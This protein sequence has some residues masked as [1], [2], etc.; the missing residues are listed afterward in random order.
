LRIISR[1]R[2]R[3]YWERH[4]DALEPLPAWYRAARLAEW[5]TLADTRRDFSNADLVGTCTVF[6]IK[7]NHYRLITKVYYRAKRIYIRTVLTHAEY[8]KGGLRNDCNA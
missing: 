5:D 2:L 7:G 4:P 6:N 3:G 1:S 8:D